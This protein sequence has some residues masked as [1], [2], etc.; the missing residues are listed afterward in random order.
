[1]PKPDRASNH[2]EKILMSIIKRE[3]QK[4]KNTFRKLTA[5]LKGIS[6]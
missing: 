5:D 1:L 2:E 4:D 3:I 6:E